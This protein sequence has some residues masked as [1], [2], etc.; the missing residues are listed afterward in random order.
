MTQPPD[1]ERLSELSHRLRNAVAG[2]RTTAQVLLGR[3]NRRDDLPESWAELVNRIVAETHNL[4]AAIGDLE[5]L[6]QPSASTGLKE[7]AGEE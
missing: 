2:I 6:A 7:P 3:L 5:N 1:A 4:E